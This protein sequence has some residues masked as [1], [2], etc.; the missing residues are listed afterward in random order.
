MFNHINGNLYHYAANNPVR[1]IDPD[2]RDIFAV[3]Q[4]QSF[5]TGVGIILG[6]VAEDVATFGA[7]F[8]DDPTTLAIGVA[9]ILAACWV[10]SNGN[11]Q[12]SPFP[13]F[14]SD[15][16]VAAASPNPL[17]PDGDDVGQ[18]KTKTINQIRDDIKV[19]F[20]KGNFGNKHLGG[21]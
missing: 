4:N 1:Y 16:N 19:V 5:W 15:A 20:R 12:A 13:L 11:N 6:T 3:A 18:K 2:G 9:L 21:N 8:A 10:T 17:P 7:G 14:G